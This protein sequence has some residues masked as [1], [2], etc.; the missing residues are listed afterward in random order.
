MKKIAIAEATEAQLRRFASDT[1]GLDVARISKIETLRAKVREAHGHDEIM[2]ADAPEPEALQ[3][4]ASPARAGKRAAA[5][6]KVKILIAATDEKG[7]DEPIP[8][9]VNGSVMLVPR[10]A[11]VE[12]PAAHY[13][14]LA[15]AVTDR[16]ETDDAGNIKPDPRRVPRFP[17]TLLQAPA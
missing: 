3:D 16:Y 11:P 14:V 1:L 2:A 8:V 13:R 15:S 7:G 17:V 9:G 4:A 6:G 12:I 5:S 10:G